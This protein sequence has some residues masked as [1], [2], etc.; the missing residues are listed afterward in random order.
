MISARHLQKWLVPVGFVIMIG[1]PLGLLF[2]K[3]VTEA[4]F[5]VM[6]TCLLPMIFLWAVLSLRESKDSGVIFIPFGEAR[7]EIDPIL[8]HSYRGMYWITGIVVIF[9]L[10]WKVVRY[11]SS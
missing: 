2:S 4:I 9:F 8:F 7:R 3:D 11:F 10:L 1:R 5:D 6:I